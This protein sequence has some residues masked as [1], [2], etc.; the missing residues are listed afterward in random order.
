MDPASRT[1]S[2]AR[3][4]LDKGVSMIAQRD[5]ANAT[6]CFVEAAS[7]AS[8]EGNRILEARAVGN[9]ASTSALCGNHEA[10]LDMF[11]SAAPAIHYS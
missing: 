3:A 2:A 8:Q 10:A 5:Y 11:R 1:E 9:I 7:V 4:L 6:Q